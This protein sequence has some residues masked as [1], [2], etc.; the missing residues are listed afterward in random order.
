M[1]VGIH[2]KVYR[3]LNFIYSL[4]SNKKHANSQSFSQLF[5]THKKKNWKFMQKKKQ[6]WSFAQPYKTS[7]HFFTDA[8]GIKQNNHTYTVTQQSNKHHSIL[9][10]EYHCV[11]ITQCIL[12]R[13]K[14]IITQ[15]INEWFTFSLPKYK[16][17]TI[18][19][20]SLKSF[21]FFY[22]T[23]IGKEIKLILLFPTKKKL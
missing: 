16:M 4:F 21:W 15:H 8:R 7:P 17:C 10:S 19:G 9:G 18:A 5:L 20:G 14:Q 12:K 23:F 6:K 13:P 1:F 11:N 22:G 2:Y 3:F